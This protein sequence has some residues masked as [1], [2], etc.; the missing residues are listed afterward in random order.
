MEEAIRKAYD[1]VRNFDRKK[2]RSGCYAPFVSLYFTSLGNVLACCKN[3]TF[4]LG[5]VANQRLKEIWKGAKINTL[6]E[7]L[8]KYRYGAGCEFCEWQISEGNYQGAFPWLFENFPVKSMTPEWPSMIEFAG[9]NTC[10]LECIMCNGE[11]S[12]SIRAHRD[13]LPPLP[14][15]YTEQFFE[16]LREFLPHLKMA[17]FLG[18][19]PFLTSECHQIWDM[20]IDAKLKI[21][22]HVTTNGTQYNAKVERVLQNLPISFSVSIDAATKETAESIRKN[23]HY[24][25][26]MTNLRCFREYAQKRRAFFSIAHCL[27]RQ[28]WHEFVDLLLIAEDLECPVFVNTVIG[29][30]Y[31]SL[32]TLPPEEVGR[33][34]DEIERRG[35]AVENKLKLNRRVW[36]DNIA[37]LR[38]KSEEGQAGKIA[39]ILDTYWDKEDEFTLAMNLARQKKFTE[40]LQEL[41]KIPKTNISYY[42]SV[43]LC[44]NIRRILGDLEG[45]DEDL[46]RAVKITAKRPEAFLY[47][48]F[49]RLDQKRNEEALKQAFHAHGMIQEGDLLEGELCEVFGKIYHRLG[50]VPEALNM[51]ER[52]ITLRPENP[53]VHV[54]KAYVFQSAGMQSQAHMEIDAAL[55]LDPNHPDA[56]NLREELGTGMS[57]LSMT[58]PPE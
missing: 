15:F 51:F 22:C 14:R 40:A 54:Q 8:A 13:G 57:G 26:V 49:L 28:N 21:P 25:E 39:K 37:K 6:R 41:R 9:S 31:C 58:Y 44:G 35:S 50:K 30:S 4:V 10:N 5:N 43:A 16:D 45:A 33:I 12:S 55:A 34:A 11:L 23:S 56:R 19:E 52:L 53:D 38:G 47:R 46:D 20:M 32:Y 24:E 29:P 36:R 3:E 27:M 42:R 7:A 18:G 48:A 17:K 1:A 2:F